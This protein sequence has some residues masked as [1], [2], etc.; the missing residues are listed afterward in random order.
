MRK[1]I[2]R[3]SSFAQLLV[4]NAGLGSLPAWGPWAQRP[5]CSEYRRDAVLQDSRVAL[6]SQAK[7][8]SGSD[9]IRAELLQNL[10]VLL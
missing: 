7:G 6:C 3:P 2:A 5:G 10:G 9:A 8:R 4:P 1:T